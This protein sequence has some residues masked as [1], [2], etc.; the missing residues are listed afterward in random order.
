MQHSIMHIKTVLQYFGATAVGFSHSEYLLP[1]ISRQPNPLQ[2]ANS[3]LE[4]IEGQ[5]HCQLRK[6]SLQT[7]NINVDVQRGLP[8][9]CCQRHDFIDVKT[10]NKIRCE[11]GYLL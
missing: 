5:W 3:V 8:K 10:G 6:S 9:Q 1:Q 4:Q 11:N 2:F 7:K